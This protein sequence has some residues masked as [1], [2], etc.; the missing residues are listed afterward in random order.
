MSPALCLTG[1]PYPRGQTWGPHQGH[2]VTDIK[3]A[4]TPN[5]FPTW[6][7][8][9]FV[10]LTLVTLYKRK[11]PGQELLVYQL[12]MANMFVI[13]IVYCYLPSFFFQDF[14]S[15]VSL[16]NLVWLVKPRCK[17]IL[18]HPKLWSGG[19][20]LRFSDTHRVQPQST[21]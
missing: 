12:L 19:S 20:S 3:E 2:W 14:F 1:D 6:P 21:S 9:N 16:Y 11:S 7:V 4:F 10:S 8:H 15:C 17:T 13:V 18:C 5:A